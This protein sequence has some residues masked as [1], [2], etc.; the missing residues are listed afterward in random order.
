[1]HLKLHVR[2]QRINTSNNSEVDRAGAANQL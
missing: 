2:V 1:M